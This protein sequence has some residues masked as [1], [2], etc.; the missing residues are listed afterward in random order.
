MRM[1]VGGAGLAV[2]VAI[3]GC[4]GGGG[5]DLSSPA[6]TTKTYLTGVG[7]GDG[8]AACSALSPTLR[9]QALQSAKSSGIKAS[10][11]A[12]LFA[13][14]KAHLSSDQRKKFLDAK[15]TKVSVSGNTATVGVA[16]ASSSPTL[17]KQGGKWLITGGIGF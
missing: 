12:S 1:M 6:A 10:S 2:A 9:Q 16:G 14:V 5:G 11:C 8:A 13:Q 7:K 15:V 4:G 3:A 17:I